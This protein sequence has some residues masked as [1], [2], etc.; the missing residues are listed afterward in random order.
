M[1]IPFAFK[2]HRII[3]IAS[4]L[5]MAAMLLNIAWL[6]INY[7]LNRGYETGILVV[8]AFFFINYKNAQTGLYLHRQLATFQPVPPR[9]RRN[10]KIY[11]GLQVLLQVYV[12]MQLMRSLPRTYYLLKAGL[13]HSYPFWALLSDILGLL[14]FVAAVICLGLFWPNLFYARQHYHLFQQSQRPQSTDILKGFE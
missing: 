12:A 11:W 13:L 6:L 1:R 8:A 9:K 4:L 14:H 2:L 7:G 5:V 3:S 10:L